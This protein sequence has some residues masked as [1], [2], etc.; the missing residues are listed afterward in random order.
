[1]E[2]ATNQSNST[3]KENEAHPDYKPFN[4]E[5]FAQCHL[6]LATHRQLRFIACLLDGKPLAIHDM[7]SLV[8]S[9]NIW[10][11]KRRLSDAGWIIHTDR[12]PFV[13]R[14]GVPVRSGFYSLDSSQI[15]IGSRMVSDAYLRKALFNGEASL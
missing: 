9:E 15:G 2:N 10:E 14:D 5:L 11:E 1:M 4:G 8:G 3:K 6:Y 7:R 12:K 13:D